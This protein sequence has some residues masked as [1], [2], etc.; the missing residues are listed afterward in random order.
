[1]SLVI[2]AEQLSY[3]KLEKMNKNK[4][5]KTG[6]LIIGEWQAVKGKCLEEAYRFLGKDR[7]DNITILRGDEVSETQVLE[8]LKTKGLFSNK[9]TIIYQEPDFLFTGIQKNLL[10]KLVQALKKAQ[11]KRAARLFGAALAQKGLSPDSLSTSKPREL[12]SVLETNAIDLEQIHEL[13]A[14]HLTDVQRGFEIKGS[15]GRLL[16]EWL[17]KR[18]KEDRPQN[19]LL[20]I[21]L[22]KMPPPSPML[23]R[24]MALCHVEDLRLP[25]GKGQKVKA[26]LHLL[27]R[28]V[29]KKYGKEMNSPAVELFLQLVGTDSD[30]AIRNELLK[31]V[32]LCREKKRISVQDVEDLVVR[33]REEEIYRFTEAFRQKRLDLALESLHLLSEQNIH[34]LVLLAAIR[35]CILR[36]F[37]IKAAAKTLQVNPDCSY[38][39]FKNAYWQDIKKILSQHGADTISKIHPYSAFVNL[40]SPH[41]ISAIYNMMEEMAELDLSLK[42]SKLKP[43]TAIERFLFRYLG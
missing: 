21:Q 5:K 23:K 15:D 9:K 18:G 32:H 25:S 8:E 17:K 20:I 37:A 12:L 30:S 4:T 24:L 26:Q 35:N 7:R 10:K 34:P 33:H 16:L 14:H 38:D 40:S 19:S 39:Q 42:G 11:F 27:I 2:R 31:L 6:I 41:K 29:L 43:R 36:I 28:N 13:L 22:S 1:M 3:P